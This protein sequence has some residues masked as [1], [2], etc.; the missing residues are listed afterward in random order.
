[1]SRKVQHSSVLYST[2]A[3]A[4]DATSSAITLTQPEEKQACS[5]IHRDFST[6]TKTEENFTS[7]G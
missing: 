3:I 1:M 2:G 4:E 7:R 6:C 5:Q